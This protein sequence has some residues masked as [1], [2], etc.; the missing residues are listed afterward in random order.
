MELLD[1]Y[2]LLKYYHQQYKLLD[3]SFLVKKYSKWRHYIIILK[4]VVGQKGKLLLYSGYS[5]YFVWHWG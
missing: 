2:S 5:H 1:Y 4:K 3:I